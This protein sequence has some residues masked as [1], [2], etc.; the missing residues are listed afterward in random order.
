MVKVVEVTKERAK[1]EGKLAKKCF[2][3]NRV[4]VGNSSI[5]VHEKGREHKLLM[6]KLIGESK[7]ILYDQDVWGQAVLFAQKY[8]KQFDLPNRFFIDPHKNY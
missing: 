1:Q 2:K 3:G 8:E 5:L 6:E 4:Y 7:L